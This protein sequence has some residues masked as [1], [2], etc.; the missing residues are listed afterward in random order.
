[1]LIKK[2]QNISSKRLYTLKDAAL[3]LGRP[4]W[5]MRELI[6]AGKMP[7]IKDGRKQYIDI[8]DLD[9]YIESNKTTM[10]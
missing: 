5:G 7:Y 2:T 4:V 1:M 8:I 9:N 6:W 3:Y 10:V